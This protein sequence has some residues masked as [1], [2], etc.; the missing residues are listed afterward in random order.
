MKTCI[1]PEC[2]DPLEKIS[3]E[4]LCTKCENHSR[5]SADRITCVAEECD[6][7]EFLKEDGLCDRCPDFERPQGDG[8]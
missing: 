3:E 6:E 8:K 2:L 5:P 4:G 7:G 1:K